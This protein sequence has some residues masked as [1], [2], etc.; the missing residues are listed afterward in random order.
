MWQE[1]IV[2]FF[3][4]CG[5]CMFGYCGIV[6][7][8]GQVFQMVNVVDIGNCFDVKNENWSYQ[9]QNGVFVYV[10]GG[11]ELF[12]VYQCFLLDLLYV[13]V[14]E[15]YFVGEFFECCWFD[16]VQVEVVFDY[17]LVFVGQL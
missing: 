11:K 5:E 17:V 9:L 13:F 7:C 2:G 4:V 14:C 6:E 1:I 8:C 12:E 3:V 15:F 10:V 16:V